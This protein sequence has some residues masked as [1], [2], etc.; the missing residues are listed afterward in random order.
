[1][2]QIN[3]NMYDELDQ[4]VGGNIM[5]YLD[6]D[7][8]VD[9]ESQQPWK[10]EHVLT[11]RDEGYVEEDT[12]DFSS[13]EDDHYHEGGGVQENL[14]FM[15][16]N[17]MSHEDI[18]EIP[19]IYSGYN[20]DTSTVEGIDRVRK[21]LHSLTR[22]GAQKR[23]T[24]SPA[25][26]ERVE[27]EEKTP[28]LEEDSSDE[29]TGVE[30]N[31]GDIETGVFGGDPETFPVDCEADLE[32]NLTYHEDSLSVLRGKVDSPLGENL[33]VWV[34][35]DTG[36]MTQLIQSE[37]AKRM[38]FVTKTIPRSKQFSINAPGGGSAR[39]TR[40]VEIDIRF[41]MAMVQEG[42]EEL[43]RGME[44]GEEISIT[45]SFGVVDNLPVPILWGGGQM[46]KYEVHDYHEKKLMTFMLP[47]GQKY[48]TA[49]RS[50]LTSCIEMMESTDV[51]VKKCVKPFMPTKERMVNMVTGGRV[52]TNVAAALYPGRDNVIRLARHNAR[53][54]EGLNQ[55]DVINEEEILEEYGNL[56]SIVS[57]VNQGEAYIVVKNNSHQALSLPAGKLEV[58][59]KPM[60]SLPICKTASPEFQ[61]LKRQKL[62]EAEEKEEEVVA[63]EDLEALPSPR[64]MI[65]WSCNGLTERIRKKRMSEV[66][67]Y[68]RDFRPD[69][70]ILQD[71]KWKNNGLS[72]MKM[73]AEDEDYR[74]YKLLLA[75]VGDR[76]CVHLNLGARRYGGQVI[77]VKNGCA[78]PTVTHNFGRDASRPWAHGRVTQLLFYDLK[79]F[80]LMAP[81]NHTSSPELLQRRAEWDRALLKESSSCDDELQT[82][83]L[84][85]F[86]A[87]LEVSDMSEDAEFWGKQQP[88]T[89]GGILPEVEDR[90]FGPTTPRVRQAFNDWVIAGD[91]VDSSRRSARHLYHK[92]WTWKG[93]LEHHVKRGMVLDYA[94]VHSS[95]VESGG[96]ESSTILQT[97]NEKNE[98][99]GSDHKPRWLSL[100]K[101]WKE[102]LERW[103]EHLNNEEREE[104]RE[105]LALNVRVDGEG[106]DS[107]NTV[108]EEEVERPL[109]FP[110][111][112]WVVTDPRQRRQVA[113][114]MKKFK[115]PIYLE[116]CI[117]KIL[118][119]LDIGDRGVEQVLGWDARKSRGKEEDIL[120][121]QALA[122]ID[123]YFFAERDT[124]EMAKDVVA[125]IN[126]TDEKAMRCRPRKTS[127][128]QQ[129]FLHAKTNQ[130]E[131]VGKL[132][133]SNSQ[134][135]H[136]LVL[137]AYE[138]RIKDFM[139]RQGATA[140]SDMFKREHETE[141]ATF[142][143]LCIDLRMLNSK[144][145]PDIFPL[146]RID[147]LIESIPRKCG[148]YSI[149]DIC[150]AFFTCE[151][152][153]E[154]RHK[155]AFKTHDR[156][157]QFAVLPQGFINSPSIFCRMIARTFKDMDREKFSAYIDDVLNHTDDWG[158]HVDVQ[159]QMYDRLRENRLTIKVSK[160]HLNQ[161]RVKFLGHI[162]TSEGRLPD[163]KAVEAINEWKDPST[164]KE[165]RSFLGATLYYREYIYQYSD[166]AMPLY[167]LIK[168]GVVVDKEWNDEVHG[169]AVRRIKQALTS[170]PVLMM[171]DNTRPFRLKV[172]ACRVG[173]GI[174]CILEQKNEQ[175]KWQPVSY[176]SSSLSKAERQYSATELECKALHD[177]IVHYAIYLKHI[178]HFEVFSD[179][180]ALKYMVKSDRATTNG[181]LMRYLMELQGYNFSLYYRKGT[182]NADA[183]AVSRLL[184]QSDEP[185]FLS[186]DE[187]RD[188]SGVVSKQMLFRAKKLDAMN[189]KAE[190]E[191]SKLLRRMAKVELQEMSQLND[192]ILAEGI[193]NLESE[194]GRQRFYDNLMK[195]GMESSKEVIEEAIQDKLGTGDGLSQVMMVNMMNCVD[196]TG[197][198]D[199]E[200]EYVEG[201]GSENVGT[202]LV[203]LVEHVKND[204]RRAEVRQGEKFDIE[205][206]G[207]RR[208][209]I[210][211]RVDACRKKVSPYPVNQMINTVKKVHALRKKPVIDYLKGERMQPNLNQIPVKP[212][213]NEVDGELSY[214]RRMGYKVV[215]VRE[216]LQ[217]KRAGLGLFAKKSMSRGQEICSYEGTELTESQARDLTV[218]RDYVASALKNQTKRE[219]I[220]IDSHDRTS[221][222][223]RYAN[224]PIDESLV[225]AKIL[226]RKDRLV[227]I[228]Q[229]EIAEGEEIYVSYSPGYWQLRLTKL[230]PELRKM[231]ELSYPDERRVNFAQEATEI[232]Y[233]VKSST[234]KG[235]RVGEEGLPVQAATKNLA[236]RTIMGREAMEETVI[237]TLE[238]EDTIRREDFEY[239]NVD[240]CEELAMKLRPILNGRKYYDNENQRLYEIYQVRYDKES[241]MIIG[242]RKPLSG[243]TDVADS[244]CYAVYGHEGLYELSE[245][246]LIDNPDKR[247]SIEWPQT[248]EMW[249]EMQREDVNLRSIIEEIKTEGVEELVRKDGRFRLLESEEEDNRVLVRIV[250]KETGPIEQR[251]V[252][253]AL[254]FLALTIHHEG[255]AHLGSSRMNAT[256]KKNYFWKGMDVAVCEHVD[257]CINCK[258]RKA[259]Q[260]R[261]R[262]PIMHYDSVSHVM[263]RVHMDLTG[264]LPTSRD[265]F[266]YV[267]VIKDFLSKYVWLIPLPNKTA[268]EVARAVLYNLI[269]QAGIPKMLISD[270]GNEFVNK[271][272]AK[273]CDLMNI[274]RVSTTPYNPRSDGFVENHNHT[275]KDQLFNFV[276]NLKQDDWDTYLPIIQ[277]MYNTTVSLSTGYTPMLLM[278]GREVRMPSM[279]HMDNAKDAKHKR[280][281]DNV[282]VGKLIE[283]TK[284]YRDSAMEHLL[285]N[286]DRLNMVV[287][288]PLE[289]VEYKVGQEFFK[290]RR[291][292]SVFKSADEE[293]QYSVTMKLLERYEGPYTIIRKVNPV[294][295]D[296]EVDGKEERVHAINMKP[297]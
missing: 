45:M 148:R 75:A 195:K 41:P 233:S 121:A 185:L 221:C 149:S 180:N 57:C 284:L 171:V 68:M 2:L 201:D 9:G 219:V 191:A 231:V 155:T 135:C 297:F 184:R 97:Y 118:K 86:N 265:G 144:T 177:C 198:S 128:V 244:S 239:H 133:D 215:E 290:V 127:A 160:T 72:N 159:Q 257:K 102:R 277:L 51:R 228:A 137:V 34:V 188:E 229:C 153:K 95:I 59:V 82:I 12:T 186:E 235:N 202:R 249:G 258:L 223:G 19:D 136:G 282:Y 3:Y 295:Y 253:S 129:A 24:R 256:M 169:E 266:K 35:S 292:V 225:N 74:Y 210:V 88:P 47:S 108:V 145:I 22:R 73:D 67:R 205:R 166:M 125:E 192:E 243:K 100:K 182:E 217:G 147:D 234:S 32:D 36:A 163:P 259:H 200:G 114:R 109:S 113:N 187:L 138:D 254:Q 288:R 110:K 90:G 280:L 271:V 208:R 183:D 287:R 30:E 226:W 131:R 117:N 71:V 161:E 93:G 141:V 107:M 241:E 77:L 17:V 151:L 267:L 167:D 152:L 92:N 44:L 130:M 84:G 42:E 260:R 122:N 269:C 274:T 170:K 252:P 79:I 18:S 222:Y 8:G 98:F 281:L 37:Y 123:V 146:P 142:F 70:I 43:T 27:E 38:K 251:M 240:Q 112:L 189:K 50:W 119:E 150:D 55:V 270:R 80:A 60:L 268:E 78:Q 40:M 261:P 293:E 263:D 49:S 291:P 16:G 15:I 242:F 272:M 14:E 203:A 81:F 164:T 236:T 216:S 245:R 63:V 39:V 58:R 273:L 168:K 179:H 156:H 279:E 101:D 66:Y 11:R 7:W 62:D 64:T 91:F 165:V 162:L 5:E 207:K 126:T 230:A 190:K 85:N 140:M 158:D 172:D 196:L 139:D 103:E 218:D 26:V 29:E 20:F 120:R 213:L 176:Y 76:Y 89:Q 83:F 48:A 33:D 116:E 154:H 275:L 13:D 294:L 96:V 204:V 283:A 54:D 99:F 1:M 278:N 285:K 173:R 178:P 87:T 193:E 25:R 31:G 46:R 143:R 21:V 238:A 134:W 296:A 175:G 174:G 52:T 209:E 94:F 211:E 28:D 250:T 289:F 206:I 227:L 237:S 6:S 224:D 56:I 69:L 264:P 4:D 286:R 10:F 23:K 111:C 124:A 276:D 248:A 197:S 157:L 61:E 181:R 212:K 115:D 247:I 199:E 220:Y 65:T 53:V 194:S 132:E 246:Y 105:V 104:Q 232:S 214:K 262:V 255:F 106:T